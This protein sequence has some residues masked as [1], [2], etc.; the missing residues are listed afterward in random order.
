MTWRARLRP[1]SFRGAGFHVERHD[2][3]GGRRLALHEY[4]NRDGVYAED[5]GRKGRGFQIAAFVIGSDY[6]RARDTLI[7]ALE[8]A[9]PGTLI[10]PFQGERTVAVEDF[11][12]AEGYREG[13]LCRFDIAFVETLTEA[14][15]ETR[16]DTVAHAVR[17]GD[18]MLAAA[19]QAFAAV[20]RLVGLPEFVADQAAL[21]AADLAAVVDALP[22]VA[23][24]GTIIEGLGSVSLRAALARQ[25]ADFAIGDTPEATAAVVTGVVQSYRDAVADPHVAA[26][27]L[28]RLSAFAAARA[29]PL[30][31]T[32][33]RAAM[34]TNEAALQRLTEQAA[35]AARAQVL[36]RTPFASADDAA[37]ARSGFAADLEAALL[38]AG[39]VGD[40][41]AFRALRRLMQAVAA[42]LT[43]RG[44]SLAPVT[45]YGVP[46]SMPALAL[47][48]RLY[49]DA[50]RAGELVARNGAIH[51][52][53]AP[54][55]GAAL[56]R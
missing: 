24:G 55:T 22:L 2:G 27:G 28:A 5:L 8:A 4:P 49:G 23:I 53:F 50:A 32:P 44:G 1:G 13:R 39:D 15:P 29:V 12:H 9:G 43:A 16:A 46:E 19:E 47:A 11:T 45:R 42:D 30:G 34:R 37:A 10:H 40:D 48:H 54:A 17:E 6:D 31:G 56:A 35:L 3:R 41:A 7:E 52:L 20:F 51:P 21:F 38:R 18:A 36:A 25:L 14:K 33:I 26:R